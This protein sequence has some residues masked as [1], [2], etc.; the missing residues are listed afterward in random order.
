MDIG[1]NDPCP[2]GSRKKYKKCCLPLRQNHPQP[3][4]SAEKEPFPNDVPDDQY[5]FVTAGEVGDYGTPV[6]TQE[7]LSPLSSK[8]SPIPS[9]YDL[10]LNLAERPE[11]LQKTN[12]LVGR[13]IFRGKEEARKIKKANSA[14]ELV[15]IMKSNSDPINHALLLDRLLEKETASIPLIISELAKPQ[16]DNFCEVAVQAIYRSRYY[17]EEDLLELVT[18]P[19]A[20][21]YDLSLICMLLGM[22]EIEEALQPLWNCYHFF[23]KKFPHREYWKGPLIG[24]AE[25]KYRQDNPIELSAEQCD[26]VVRNLQESGIDIKPAMANRIVDLVYARRILK[27]LN[28]LSEILGEPND[29]EQAQSE[30]RQKLTSAVSSLVP[31][32]VQ[33]DLS[34]QSDTKG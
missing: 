29:D 16:R 21:A 23:K 20:T 3:L 28:T 15:E 7:F 18:E 13:F 2:C 32:V 8:A 6:L 27:L 9:S 26:I 17:P 19:N 22:L 25:L 14:E 30:H 5:E 34:Q 24:L 4:L 31:I 1:R 11:L 12:Q 33:F 10:I